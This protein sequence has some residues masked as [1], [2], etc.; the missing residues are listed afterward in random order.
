MVRTKSAQDLGFNMSQYDN[1]KLY[2]KGSETA[3]KRRDIKHWRLRNQQVRGESDLF[4]LNGKPNKQQAL[5]YMM[6]RMPGMRQYRLPRMVAERIDIGSDA[7]LVYSFLA[8]FPQ[9]PRL[10]QAEIAG[11][12]G[13]EIRKVQSALYDLEQ[14]GLIR[15]K[16]NYYTA[17]RRAPSTYIRMPLGERFNGEPVPGILRNNL[18]YL[19]NKINERFKL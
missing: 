14:V 18:K 17:R 4:G 9:H 7:K 10:Y 6:W 2:P 16:K 11:M 13:L 12:C 15:A 1:S 8:S 19:E 3:E 5:Q